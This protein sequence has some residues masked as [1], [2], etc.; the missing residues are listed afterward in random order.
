MNEKLGKIKT[1]ERDFIFF[2]FVA[3]LVGVG[4]SVDSA[5]FNNFLKDQFG[6]IVT[7]RTLLE[8]PR[9]LPGLLVFIFTGL[10]FVLGDIRIAAIANIAAAIGMFLL[11]IIP[12]NIFIMLLVVFIYSS[13]QHLFMPYFN[14]I[15]MSFAEE[16]KLGRRLGRLSAVMNISLVAAS[17]LLWTLFYFLHISY[18]V[19]FSIGALAF[20]G[21]AIFLLFMNKQRVTPQTERFV[22]R[23]EYGLYYWLNVLYGARKQ[24][25]LTFA[26][27]VLVDVFHQKVT[28]MTM[29]FFVV[30]CLG[31]VVKPL[32]GYLIDKIGE[33]IILTG[34]AVILFFLCL[35]Y[36]FAEDLFPRTVA[37]VV[38]ASCYVLDMSLDAVMMAR[39]TYAKKIALHEDD[40]SPTLS[41]GVSLDHVVSMIIPLVGGY[42]WVLAGPGGYK[43]VFLG[44]ALIALMNFFSA[45]RIVINK[46]NPSKES[47]AI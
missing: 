28:T 21:A 30:A 7:Q 5:T 45:R 31:I 9:E 46:E 44:G 23:K 29:L 38:V 18:L 27:W 35:S 25:F 15:S 1:T 19:S 12:N 22:I 8:L 6:F 14:S 26:P 13:G 16:D 11:G 34:E 40:V 4:Q 42:I 2:L 39:A 32:L 47:Q 36:A 24:I 37:L 33:R 41:L 17:A 3:V 43:Y 10:L 20:L